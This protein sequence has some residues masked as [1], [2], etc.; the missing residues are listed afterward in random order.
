MNGSVVGFVQPVNGRCS[1]PYA[2]AAQ[3]T[4]QPPAAQK[5]ETLVIPSN[6]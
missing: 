6:P 4:T 1:G 2:R 3:A 5:A